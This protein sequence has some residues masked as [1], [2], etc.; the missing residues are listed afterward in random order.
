MKKM[1]SLLLTLCLC[2]LM[3][4]PAGA[5][6]TETDAEPAT[7]GDAVPVAEE[8]VETIVKFS[9]I[10]KMHY[11][12]QLEDD[13]VYCIYNTSTVGW[14][15]NEPLQFRVVTYSTFNFADIII[16]ADGEE[17]VPDGNG[18]YSLPTNGGTMSVS[19]SGAARDDS[20]PNGKISFWDLLL[21]FLQKIIAV[22]T[23]TFGKAS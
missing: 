16:Y 14:C 10:S 19:A 17:L 23:G 12:I 7:P 3:L 9:C 1:L 21:Q 15:S 4:L 8:P 11:E 5:A 18:I 13:N 22:L 6:A 2:A 20:A